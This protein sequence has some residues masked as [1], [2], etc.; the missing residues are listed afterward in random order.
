[1]SVQTI[2]DGLAAVGLTGVPAVIAAAGAAAGVGMFAGI[3]LT[4]VCRRASAGTRQAPAAVD[5]ALEASGAASITFELR[6]D[7]LRVREVSPSIR[8]MTGYDADALREG[9]AFLRMVHEHA[10]AG[11]ERRLVAALQDERACV[12]DAPY[13]DAEGL[14]RW[15]QVRVAPPADGKGG[16]RRGSV[17]RGT[18]R[19]IT[20]SRL[21]QHEVATSSSRF[22]ALADATPAMLWVMDSSGAVTGV[23]RA[24]ERFCGVSE[25]ALLGEGWLLAVDDAERAELQR[26]VARV[27]DEGVSLS[28]EVVMIDPDGRDRRIAMTATVARDPAGTVGSVVLTGR[29]VTDRSV[30]ETQ[31]ERLTR[32]V[33]TIGSPAMI[34]SPDFR[35]AQMNPAARALAGIADGENTDSIALWHVVTQDAADVIRNEAARYCQEGGVFETRAGIRDGADGS[36]SAEFSVVGLGDGWLGVSA[37][38]V[39][40]DVALEAEAAN[41]RQQIEMIDRVLQGTLPAEAGRAAAA[42][43]VCA[44][45]AET[46]P[47]FRAAFGVEIEPGVIRCDASNG[48]TEMGTAVGRRIVLDADGSLLASLRSGEAVVVGDVW[49]DAQLERSVLAFESTATRAVAACPVAIGRGEL[50][51]LTIER[52]TPGRFRTQELRAL[53]WA[54]RLLGAALAGIDDREW[55]HRAEAEASRLSDELCA[56]RQRISGARASAEKAIADASARAAERSGDAWAAALRAIGDEVRGVA[57]LA[58]QARE[59]GLERVAAELESID[60]IGFRASVAGR[61]ATGTLRAEAASVQP[62][63]VLRAVGRRV[64][65]SATAK[66]VSLRIS[67]DGELP[68]TLATDGGL[69]SLACDQLLGFAVDRCGSGE[70]RAI[71]RSA[72]G[73]GIELSLAAAGATPPA[74]A[75]VGSSESAGVLRGLALVR[76]VAHVLG[77]TLEIEQTSAA[78]DITLRVADLPSGGDRADE[79]LEAE[80]PEAGD[81]DRLAA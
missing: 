47:A 28:R 5:D 34:L 15:M 7:T 70:V 79:L 53:S 81:A 43:R 49:A 71:A 35:V 19:E 31:R 30:A 18:V 72:E 59:A 32:L 52:E 58:D 69:L 56:E 42:R 65:A 2:A 60:A 8:A 76:A 20:E 74:D 57:G 3:V 51:V 78:T 66:G 13:D 68:D 36:L 45:L 55:R 9:D 27:L 62:K 12:I 63:D 48:P 23:N 14:E 6:K 25:A 77:G 11:L 40:Q 29:D 46:F 39:E 64:A 54:S 22:H 21:L 41:E 67:K 44:A 24:T 26:F 73:G 17:L 16:S 10:A 1:M 33:D 80:G 75:S 38:I 37:K 61:A 50:C 4:V